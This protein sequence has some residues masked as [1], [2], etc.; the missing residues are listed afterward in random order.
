MIIK[1]MESDDFA[2]INE[3]RNANIKYL[4]QTKQQNFEEQVDW[5]LN[6]KDI[7]FTL[8][9]I[10]VVGAVGLTMIDHINSRCELSLITESY[11]KSE[12]AGAG[13]EFAMNYAFSHLGMKKFFCTLYEYDDKKP[14]LLQ[15]FGWKKECTIKN[16][17]YYDGKY[18]DHDYWRITRKE[19]YDLRQL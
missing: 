15:S 7:Y 3:I 6:T 13:L 5:Y 1:R 16:D 8:F 17:V 18:W 11:I 4:R 2:E 14:A 10:K 9:D 19:Y 12:Y